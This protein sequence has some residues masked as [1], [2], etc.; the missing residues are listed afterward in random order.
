[1]PFE[2]PQQLA[3]DAV[4]AQIGAV[5]ASIQS[6]ADAAA[7]VA[8]P[9]TAPAQVAAAPPSG[10]VTQRETTWQPYQAP[11]T[12]HEHSPLLAPPAAVAMAPP[13]AAAPALVEVPTEQAPGE[14][15]GQLWM[16]R[17][18]AI[19][20]NS[21]AAGSPATNMGMGFGLKGRR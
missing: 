12:A 8:A 9:A 19:A 20:Q 18:Q 7:P 16:R 5:L 4:A 3:A 2:N 21:K 14:N 6:K 10:V 15:L 1:M 13:P 11:P 17:A